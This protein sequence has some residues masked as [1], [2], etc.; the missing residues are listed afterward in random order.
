MKKNL[1]IPISLLLAG[2]AFVLYKNRKAKKGVSV[3][4]IKKQ[5]EEAKKATLKEI[6]REAVRKQYESLENPNSFKGKVARIQLFLGVATDGIVGPQ[7]LLALSQKLPFY[8][9]INASNV[10]FIL[11]DLAKVRN[12]GFF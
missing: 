9:T 4:E 10:D 8:T 7:T 1:I 11:G 3:D 5:Q 2:G 6:E 12:F